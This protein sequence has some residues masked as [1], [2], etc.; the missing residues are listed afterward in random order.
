MKKVVALWV[1]TVLMWV[2]AWGQLDSSRAYVSVDG[3]RIYYEVSGDGHPLVFIHGFTLDGRMWAPQWVALKKRYRTVRYDVRG[4]GRS[5][6]VTSAH[7]PAADLLALLDHL[8]IAQ[9]HLVGLSMGANIAL[10]FAVRYP[11]RVAKVVAADPNL[12]GFTDY[13][14]ALFSALRQV[15]G[16][17]AQRG[18]NA[19]TQRLWLSNPLLQ[20]QRPSAAHQALLAQM[21]SSYNGD[22]LVNP[23]AAPRYGEPSTL[24]RLD[25][26]QVPVLVLVGKRDE[27]SIQ[28]IARLIAQ[29]VPKA[30]LQIIPGAGHLSNLDQPKRFNRLVCRFLKK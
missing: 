23:A 3:G 7:D 13:T 26:I 11:Q 17:V 10:N 28:R 5:S 16:A 30:Q 1:C 24:L 29:K 21:V 4:F 9:A 25:S 15:F 27:E 8:G 20:L 12:D 18:W 22:Q 14:P 19:E 2:T 6:R